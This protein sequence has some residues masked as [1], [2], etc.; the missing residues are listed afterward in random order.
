M[1]YP[2]GIEPAL[3][4]QKPSRLPLRIRICHSTMAGTRFTSPF[5]VTDQATLIHSAFPTIN[6]VK[7]MTFVAEL[8]L[9][10]LN[11]LRE[12]TVMT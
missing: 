3:G 6:P 12:M 11:R 7:R 9:I 2:S 5:S 4:R 1:V 10:L 8:S